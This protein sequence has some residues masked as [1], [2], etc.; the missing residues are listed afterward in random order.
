MLTGG[1]LSST[2]DG[3]LRSP[4]MANLYGFLSQAV[5]QFTTSPKL[6]KLGMRG[7]NTSEVVFEDVKVPG[8][9]AQY[10]LCIFSGYCSVNCK[11]CAV[12]CILLCTLSITVH[13]QHAYPLYT[14]TGLHN[15]LVH[16][17]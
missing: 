10:T 16:V 5:S 2:K 14:I 13:T 15:S 11:P 17:Y 8:Q 12:P 7:S 3:L 9:P 1:M 4:I 6:D